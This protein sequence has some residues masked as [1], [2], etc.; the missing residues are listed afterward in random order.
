M[1]FVWRS[2]NNVQKYVLSFHLVDSG[3]QTRV[4]KFW[5]QEPLPDELSH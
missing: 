5:W 1:V 4:V 3:D 2:E